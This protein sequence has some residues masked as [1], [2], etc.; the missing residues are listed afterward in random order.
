MSSNHSASRRRFLDLVGRTGLASVASLSGVAASQERSTGPQRSATLLKEA[1]QS[2]AVESTQALAD[3]WGRSDNYFETLEVGADRRSSPY[4]A[5]LSDTLNETDGPDWKQVSWPKDSVLGHRVLR[6]HWNKRYRS[7]SFRIPIFKGHVS[8]TGDPTEGRVVHCRYM[9]RVSE[10]F[11]SA[12]I[13]GGK[14]PGFSSAGRGWQSTRA[15]WPRHVTGGTHTL[16][17]G[18]GDRDIDGTDGWSARGGYSVHLKSTR[19]PVVRMYSFCCLL[20]QELPDG[21][22]ALYDEFI[23]R[24]KE[25]YAIKR[26]QGFIFNKP[27]KHLVGD[28]EVL[29]RGP[30]K[31]GTAFWWELGD[32]KGVLTPNRWYRIDKIMSI[33][34]PGKRD[35]WIR[36]Y[37]DGVQ[38]AKVEKLRWRNP[39]PYLV[40][41]LHG[42]PTTLGIASVWANFYQGGGSGYLKMTD[43]A[44]IDVYGVAVRVLEW[45]A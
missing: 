22:I 30:H 44:Y 14:W 32:R 7:G 33:N 28:G 13:E 8:Q 2:V 11:C 37:I 20:D 9:V 26:G 23:R 21:R 38:V 43:E 31:T 3:I 19:L 1:G 42:V 27:Y 12:V 36:A 18:N 24:Y 17:A 35:G 34:T 45:D 16:L 5:F 25:H 41:A 29:L 6:I 40:T 39:G 4:E 15:K 10:N